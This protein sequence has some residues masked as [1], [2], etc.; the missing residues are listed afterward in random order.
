MNRKSNH[1]IHPNIPVLKK[2]DMNNDTTLN[3]YNQ[4]VTL[5]LFHMEGCGYC[6][7]FIPEIIKAAEILS[8]DKDVKIVTTDIVDFDGPYIQEKVN[9][10]GE[11]E[12]VGK[13][14]DATLL[15]NTETNEINEYKLNADGSF[16]DKNG[17]IKSSLS[18]KKPKYRIRG[19]PKLVG[20]KNGKFYAVYSQ[21]TGKFRTAKDVIAFVNGIKQGVKVEVDP[22]AAA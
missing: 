19:F 15:K 17:K 2:E 22:K 16:M 11:Y 7:Q 9:S 21:G 1:Q 3:K 5:I 12:I 4:G 13:K 20:Y 10:I 18:Y 8:N 14:G 6:V